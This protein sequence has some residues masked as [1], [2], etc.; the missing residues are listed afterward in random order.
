MTAKNGSDSR[1]PMS[2][3]VKSSMRFSTTS[4]FIR[5]WFFIS[6]PPMPS[7]ETACDPKTGKTSSLGRYSM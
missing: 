4:A 1:N 7:M 5:P 2:A 3:S 6:S